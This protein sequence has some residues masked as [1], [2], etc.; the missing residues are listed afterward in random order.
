MRKAKPIDRR[1]FFLDRQRE[2]AEARE[3]GELRL[4]SLRQRAKAHKPRLIAERRRTPDSRVVGGA[5]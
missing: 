4:D 1:Q 5:G 2:V 3:A